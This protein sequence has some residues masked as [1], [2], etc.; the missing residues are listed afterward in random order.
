MFAEGWV[1][2]VKKVE[3][4]RNNNMQRVRNY[5]LTRGDLQQAAAS[6]LKIGLKIEELARLDEEK[7]SKDITERS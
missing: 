4:E 2:Q 1:E 7:Y 6:N 3:S 5:Q